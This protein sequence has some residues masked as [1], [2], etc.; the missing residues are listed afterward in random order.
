VQSNCI[1]IE[2]VE[3]EFGRKRRINQSSCNKDYS[4]VKGHCPSFVSVIGGRLRR[5]SG[6]AAGAPDPADDARFAELP[7]PAPPPLDEPFNVL[8]AGIGG[9]GVITLGALLGM[10]A[11]LEGRG[12]SVLDVTGLAQK[13]GPVTSHVRIAASPDR[14]HATRISAGGADLVLGCDM[15]VASSPENLAKLAKGRTTPI[16]NSQVA[17]TS[18]FASNPDLDLSGADMR[19][20]IEAGAGAQ[21]CH[22][23][24]ATQLATALLGDAIFTNPFL[25]GYAFQHGHLPVSQP[26]LE[27]AIELNGRATDANRRAF[28]WGRLAAYDLDAV[29]AAARPA[30]RGAGE[31]AA[32]T[33]ESLLAR[34]AAFLTDYQNAAYASRYRAFVDEVSQRAAHV[35]GGERL[36]AA[37]ARQLFKLMARKDEY[38]VARLYTDGSFQRQLDAEFEGDYR[39]VLHLAPPRLPVLD[40]LLDRRDADTG[41]TRKIDSR[42]WLPAMRVLAKLKLLRDTPF[43][44]FGRT[45]H[46]RLE[47]RLVDDYRAT[48]GE[49][50]AG[51]DAGNLA[52]AVEIASLPEHIRG[53]ES[54]REEHLAQVQARQ[55]EL[56][57]AF[58][59]ATPAGAAS[60]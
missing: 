48:I 3:T 12:C 38:E 13:N 36:A 44:P 6:G 58:R 46:R 19:A 59:A 45:R 9:S 50:L 27:R 55:A 4:C 54:V 56:L 22:F 31:A 21:A 52:V 32:E 43:D 15:V 24:P 33:L 37:V 5:T 34:R 29:L 7:A 42:W 39:L 51:L 18:D 8:V 57:Q 49:L 23:V 1:S 10:A 26:A 16:V 47:R 53:F 25:L 30:L 40:W 2:P 41:R 35:A 14:L 28:A 17:P 11:H 60:A 20:A